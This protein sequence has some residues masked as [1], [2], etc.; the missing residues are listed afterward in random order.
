MN[1][2]RAVIMPTFSDPSGLR[3]WLCGK[4]AL[5]ARPVQLQRLGYVSHTGGG[6]LHR[7]ITPQGGATPPERRP[8]EPDVCEATNVQESRLPAQ[9]TDVH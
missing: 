2:K 9:R 7:Y 6:W 1:F 4:P 8:L 3:A 5:P